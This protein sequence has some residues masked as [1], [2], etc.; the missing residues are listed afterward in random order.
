MALTLVYPKWV[1]FWVVQILIVL[2]DFFDVF[3]FNLLGDR[4][5]FVLLGFKFIDLIVF[6][7][8]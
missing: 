7:Q 4:F 2:F 1:N 3:L 5:L 6:V 8:S